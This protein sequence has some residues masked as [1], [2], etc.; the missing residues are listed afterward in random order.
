MNIDN[1]SSDELIGFSEGSSAV[2][3]AAR[4]ELVKRKV[5]WRY[6]ARK[7]FRFRVATVTLCADQNKLGLK[8]AKRA[9][10]DFYAE[11]EKS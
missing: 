11:I 5:P 7:G 4:A 8:D 6:V 10:Y 9:V 2:A 3:I 1:M